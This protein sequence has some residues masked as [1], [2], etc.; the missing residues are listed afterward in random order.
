LA[1]ARK[2]GFLG[3]VALACS[4]RGGPELES[5]LLDAGA[6]AS[7][8]AAAPSSCP[9]SMFA[10]EPTSVLD[11]ARHAAPAARLLVAGS[12]EAADAL[13][14]SPLPL[15]VAP[16][17]F[18]AFHDGATA[19]VIGQGE[20]GAMYGAFEI[21]EGTSLP[22]ARKPAVSIRAYNP[23]LAI[24]DHGEKCWYFLDAGYW[25]GYLDELARSR[26][27]VLDLHAMYNLF[28]T[29]SPNA[30]LYFAKSTTYP[31]VG[32][33][34]AERER[35]MQMLA[36]IVRMAKVRG[37][38][39]WFLSARSD[40][41][42]LA[43]GVKDHTARLDEEATKVY[44][45]EA[46]LDLAHRVPD[47]ERVGVRIGESTRP[48]SWYA[49]TWGAALANGPKFYT[50]TWWTKKSEVLAL[51]DTPGLSNDP[52]VEVKFS[53]EHL[54][55]W[56][57]QGGNFAEQNRERWRPSYLYED[58]LD[59]PQPYDFVFQIWNSATY[60][61][62]RFVS[63][64]LTRRVLGAMHGISNR[65]RGFSLQAAHAYGRQRDFWHEEPSDRY[66][67]WTYSRDAMEAYL[68]GRLGY[69]PT[70]SDDVFAHH[71]GRGPELW[72]AEQAATELVSWILLAHE[73]GPDSRD[74]APQ[75]E[76]GGDLG[77][78]A[79]ASK[80]D[81]KRTYCQTGFHGPFDTFAV[82]SPADTAS[83]LV[84]GT[85]T[86]RLSA[87]DVAAKILDLARVARTAALAHVEPWDKEG[88]DVQREAIAVASLGDYTGHKLRAATAFAVHARTG[89]AAWR[90]AA[91]DEIHQAD[92]AWRALAD[93]TVYIKPFEDPYR[94]WAFGLESFHWKKETP[95]LAADLAALEAQKPPASA[96]ALPEP[97]TWLAT[98]RP[99]P[100]SMTLAVEPPDPKAA[101][102]TVTATFTEPVT[103]VNVLA[104]PFRA[105]L[106]WTSVPSNCV[107]STCKASI[108][109]NPAERGGVFAVEVRANGH[110][111]RL[112]DP[113][114]GVPYVV[115]AP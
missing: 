43:D 65:P 33:A 47:L 109:R 105:E 15:D 4:C 23:Y 2:L 13:R 51:V 46:V 104:K 108:A 95:W 52:V 115:V 66:S 6:D 91:A 40:A 20:V 106:P 71:F 112:P 87:I 21:G 59:D 27:N 84:A 69:D 74:F 107:S 44:T 3:A 50:R 67:E 26:I 94:M 54:A 56:I 55:P 82:A 28:N 61:M 8:E 79:S 78:W 90:A 53:A 35:N 111:W 9:P 103:S 36:T 70:V 24:P 72:K 98:S 96:T 93:A 68:F 1:H 97:T 39:V 57:P 114:S 25:R 17:S 86:T 34:A 77:Y 81:P 12:P 41:N 62:F 64:S 85:P 11:Y 113:S 38:R 49:D 101:T 42:P 7:A 58:Y 80:Q 89:N 88:R 63:P 60:R 102:W 83:D 92:E 5:G 22:I 30:L 14:R 16:E 76:W 19:V 73:C 29:T 37:I 75:L 31:D 100:P 10:D 45:R 110:G 18:V 32:I 48:A 99:A